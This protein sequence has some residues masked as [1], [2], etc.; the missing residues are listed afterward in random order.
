[1]LVWILRAARSRGFGIQSPSDYAFVRYVVNE[2]HPYHAYAE[3]EAAYAEY[4]KPEHKLGRLYFRL[5]NHFQADSWQAL[6]DLLPLHLIYIQRGCRKTRITTWDGSGAGTQRVYIGTAA[7]LHISPK[8]LLRHM[9]DDSVLVLEGIRQGKEARMFWKQ[10]AGDERAT[11]TF[12]LYD[13][14]I[15]FFDRRRAKQNYKINF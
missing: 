10:I 15:A 7:S 6:S 3:L 2:H 1:M 11:I 8:V 4:P 9:S 13:A 14:G 5:A 12:D